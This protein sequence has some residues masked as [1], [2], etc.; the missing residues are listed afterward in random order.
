MSIVPSYTDAIAANAL[1]SPN[2]DGQWFRWSLTPPLSVGYQG[3]AS[4]QRFDAIPCHYIS[5][6]HVLTSCDFCTFR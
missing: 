4:N 3:L 2:R 1:L 5:M 6:V